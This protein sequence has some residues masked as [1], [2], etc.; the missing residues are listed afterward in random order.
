MNN[1]GPMRTGIYV[2]KP[3]TVTIRASAPEDARVQLR[4]FRA[5]AS[6]A[7][8]RHLREPDAVGTHQ[9]DAG[10]YLIVSSCPMAIE[11]ANL[12]TQTVANDKNPWPDPDGAVAGLV[13][14]ATMAAIR[15]FFAVTKGIEVGDAAEPPA[16][17]ARITD[18]PDGI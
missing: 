18:E 11:G 15:D 4:R 7:D 6:A 10:I 9:L 17:T 14:N 8:A 13:V 12:T 5:A 2:Q 16:G 1:E 3:T